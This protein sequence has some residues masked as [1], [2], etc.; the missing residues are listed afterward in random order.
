MEPK[1][2]IPDFD[3]DALD[4]EVFSTSIPPKNSKKQSNLVNLLNKTYTKTALTL[5][6]L[7]FLFVSTFFIASR[8][9]QPSFT[10][11][12]AS[13]GYIPQ[14][15]IEI[16]KSVN[17]RSCS[18][19]NTETEGST[20]LKSFCRGDWC[21]YQ[22]SKDGCEKVDVVIVE[23]ELLSEISGRDGNPDCKWIETES[24]CEPIY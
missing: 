17:V 11:S 3:V 12:S 10:T 9:A 20:F 15:I 13:L 23:D 24:V 18:D 22:I 8:V 14:A 5:T 19:V 2:D 21:S 16:P 4:L 1:K 6:L 7:L